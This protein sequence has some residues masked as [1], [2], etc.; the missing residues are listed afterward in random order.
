MWQGSPTQ[1]TWS[2]LNRH[3]SQCIYKWPITTRKKQFDYKIKLTCWVSSFK[4]KMKNSV[5]PMW[6]HACVMPALGRLGQELK[7]SLEN[8]AN[9]CLKNKSKV[10]RP[11]CAHENTHT[12]CSWE[13]GKPRAWVLCSWQQKVE[14]KVPGLWEEWEWLFRM[15]GFFYAREKGLRSYDTIGSINTV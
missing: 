7:I 14:V 15:Q 10:H 9:P 1:N 2:D 12:R 4:K 6:S 13:S 3:F 8:I 11:V 5:R